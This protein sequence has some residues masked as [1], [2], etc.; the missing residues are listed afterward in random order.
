MIKRMKLLQYISL[1]ACVA[2]LASCESTET[3]NGGNQEAKRR[4]AIQQAEQNDRTDEAQR[5]LW[6]AQQDRLNR[7]GTAVRR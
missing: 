7:D 5:N 4:A 6:N 2:F 1:I 3:A